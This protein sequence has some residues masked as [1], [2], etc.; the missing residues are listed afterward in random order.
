MVMSE[1]EF[2]AALASSTGVQIT[3]LVGGFFIIILMG[4]IAEACAPEP[5][6]INAGICGGLSLLMTFVWYYL[7][8]G[9]APIWSQVT[10]MLGVLPAAILGGWLICSLKGT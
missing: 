3:A 5:A 6:L 9:S 8:P 7:E 2:N 4:V 1:A 10:S